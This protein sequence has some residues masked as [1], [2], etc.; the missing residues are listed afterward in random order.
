MDIQQKL[1][2]FYKAITDEAQKQRAEIFIE[3]RDKI[4]NNFDNAFQNFCHNAEKKIKSEE[5]ILN[6][7]LNQ[8]ISNESANAR[9]NLFALRNQLKNEL[10][11][12]VEKRLRDFVL[13]PEY[14][15][16]MITKFEKIDNNSRVEIS[17]FDEKLLA[18]MDNF[19]FESFKSNDDFIG[20]FKIYLHNSKIVVDN[21]FQ[22]KL[23]NVKENF[24][25]FKLP[26]F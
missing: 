11:N 19:T 6:Q 23:Q 1:S 24:N 8:A 5:L 9:K 22:S 17:K 7:H 15:Q 2:G 13:T 21:S 25:M 26:N 14:L 4:K 20:G 18:C 16:L 10:F 3:M 12:E